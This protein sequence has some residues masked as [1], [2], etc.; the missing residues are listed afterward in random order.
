MLTAL[1]VAGAAQIPDAVAQI[2]CVPKVSTL[3]NGDPTVTDGALRVAVDGL[4][5]FGR[6]YGAQD[7]LFNPPGPRGPAG[8]TFSSGVYMSSADQVLTDCFD[9]Q[10]SVVDSETSSSLTTHRTIGTLRLDLTQT[11]ASIDR[12]TSALTQT[13]RFTNL[14]VEIEAQ[15]ALVRH[16][17]ASLLFDGS[18]SDASGAAPDGAFLYQ[19]EPADNPAA[20][21]TLV[22][23]T[24]SLAGDG[25]P[26]LWTIQPY[27]YEAVIK[28]QNGIAPAHNGKV[29]GGSDPTQSQ[30]W[31]ATI[32]PGGDVTLTT[33]TRFG[34]PPIQHT[35]SV[36]TT[37]DGAVV[38]VPGGIACPPTCSAPY[39]EGTNVSLAV[40]PNPG[41]S[42]AGWEGACSGTGDC[43]VA[44]NAP[45]S[46]TAHFNPP[47]PTPAQNVNA[48]PVRGTVLVREPGSNRFVEL[49]ATD[50]LP[51]GTQ[52]DTTNGSIRLTAARAGGAT[53][54]S[55]FFD[56]V[57][58][59]EQANP[60]ALTELQLNGGD[61]SCL[62][63][64]FSV[65]AK[66]KRPVRRLWGS[67]KGKY[68]TRG[69]YS[70]ATVRGT[71][72]KTEDRCD[73]TLTEVEEGVV[74]VRDFV[75]NVDVTVRAGQSYLAEPLDRSVSQAGCTKI[76]TPGKDTL[77]G[78]SR[79]D[80]LCGLGGDDVLLG[81]GGKD[82]LYGGDGN[83]WLDGG[84]GNDYLN[85]GAGRD[86]L[87]G[88]RGRDYL[89]G[90]NGRDL[91][92]TRD[93]VRGNDRIQGG[94]GRDLCRTD[95]VRVCP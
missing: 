22:G 88:N 38:S 33:V 9:N 84:A 74:A 68:R 26:D 65:Q 25:T 37:G 72:W 53:D 58:T 67:G 62:E 10:A 30:Q 13:Y 28:A 86:R 51:V 75:R 78:T 83:D 82:R 12:R 4:G 43:T 11:L 95:H 44:M 31:N 81:M 57:F 70:A 20:P 21:P 23:I 92:I 55:E 45:R 76:G 14:D 34:T 50:Q 41:W 36:A 85:G 17:D 56:G 66:I 19:H 90:G 1:T 93:T 69:R 32:A 48:T 42:F 16:L 15:L 29:E 89:W 54:T 60:S 87:D 61:F 39:D 47:P 24:G 46:V 27:D 73:G 5:A 49:S 80:V 7:G 3:S 94:S 8:T 79:R 64:T 71:R 91:L 59:I 6:K 2:P 63:G 52:V 18:P 40:A 77:R 35:L